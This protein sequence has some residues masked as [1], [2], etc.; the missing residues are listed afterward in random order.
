ML[1]KCPYCGVWQDWPTAPLKVCG[2]CGGRLEPESIENALPKAQWKV[3]AGD[4]VNQVLIHYR[5]PDGEL[6]IE[7]VD[8]ADDIDHYGVMRKEVNAGQCTQKQAHDIGKYLLKP[9]SKSFYSYEFQ[10][11]G[12]VGIKISPELLEDAAEAES[13]SAYNA[14]VHQMLERTLAIEDKL[15]E[16]G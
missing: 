14:F 15:Y 2:M 9:H 3:R 5:N 1:T 13:F 8:D 4:Y 16:A 10:Y 6:W 11:S 7:Q 12:N